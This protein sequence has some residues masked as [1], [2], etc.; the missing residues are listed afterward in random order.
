M[1]KDNMESLNMMKKLTL[2]CFILCL[3]AFCF[4]IILNNKIDRGLFL[5]MIIMLFAHLH[6][7]QAYSKQIN[8]QN[9]L[10]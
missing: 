3:I 6:S 10:N 5:A 1:K 7:R 4:G 8:Q 9:K 2:V